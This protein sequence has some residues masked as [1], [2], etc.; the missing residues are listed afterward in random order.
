LFLF[1]NPPHHFQFCALPPDDLKA[2]E[3]STKILKTRSQNP[4]EFNLNEREAEEV[5]VM[6][7]TRA[8]PSERN[9]QRHSM[10]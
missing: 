3:K 1:F 6:L 8:T 5:G 2:A 4:F 10:Q 9:K 7:G